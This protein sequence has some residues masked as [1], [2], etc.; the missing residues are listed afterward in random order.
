MNPGA[1]MRTFILFVLLLLAQG[2]TT[3]DAAAFSNEPNGFWGVPWGAPIDI[4]FSQD[5]FVGYSSDEKS[6]KYQVIRENAALEV[7]NVRLHRI[8]YSFYKGA[9]WKVDLEARLLQAGKLLDLFKLRYGEPTKVTDVSPFT[10]EYS[11]TGEHSDITLASS[12]NFFDSK[13]VDI[14]TA[15]LQSKKIKSQLDADLEPVLTEQKLPIDAISGFRDKKWGSGFNKALTY[16]PLEQEPFYVYLVKGDDMVYEGVYAREIRYRFHNNRTLQKVELHF[17]GKQNYLKLK[18]ACFK[19]FG[20]TS[21]FEQGEIRWIGR[22]T[23]ASL[24]LIIDAKG[25]WLSRLD[26]FGFGTQ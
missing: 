19:L 25:T 9:M 1:A 24:S 15:T 8:V 7:D 10:R 26:L 13:T 17:S 4:N 3:P 2:V 23:T 22:K 11:W 20:I 6:S 12:L 14:A 21:R 18:A 5:D 16:L